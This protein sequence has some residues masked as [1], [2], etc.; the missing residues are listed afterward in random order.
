MPGSGAL[1]YDAATVTVGP[2]VRLQ[3][4]FCNGAVEGL[5]ATFDAVLELSIPRRKLSNYMVWTRPSL[6][7]W[8]ALAEAH[9]APGDEAMPGSFMFAQ[10]SHCEGFSCVAQTAEARR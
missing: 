7:R 1:D 2:Y 4:I 8:I 10:S 3:L 5:T 9:H 6:P